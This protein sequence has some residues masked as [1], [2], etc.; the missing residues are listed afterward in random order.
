M[1]RRIPS[2]TPAFPAQIALV[3]EGRG[4]ESPVGSG[5]GHATV[6]TAWSERATE[7]GVPA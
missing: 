4:F 7:P 6:I 5:T 3:M 2:H 1:G